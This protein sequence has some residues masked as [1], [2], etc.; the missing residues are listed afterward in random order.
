MRG[1]SNSP[2]A[3][4]HSVDSASLQPLRVLVVTH[5]A[6]CADRILAEFEAVGIE[7]ETAWS[8]CEAAGA[9]KSRAF[10]AVVLDPDF[11]DASLGSVLAWLRR[12]RPA[13]AILIA[14]DCELGLPIEA[15]EELSGLSARA[16]ADGGEILRAF[17]RT[18]GPRA[19]LT[20]AGAFAPPAARP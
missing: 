3:P 17:V 4:I 14:G 20:G 1:G 6:A 12:R 2:P 19:F 13:P 16:G 9:L 18:I 8:A 11:D 10:S 5:D 7:A 15:A